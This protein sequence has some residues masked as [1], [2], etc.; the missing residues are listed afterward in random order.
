VF[1][2]LAVYISNIESYREI[3]HN[4]FNKIKLTQT[5]LCLL[6]Y[7]CLPTQGKTATI[8]AKPTAA[9]VRGD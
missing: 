2:T 7:T 1:A 4:E 5:M 6:D 8:Y 3:T 9:T